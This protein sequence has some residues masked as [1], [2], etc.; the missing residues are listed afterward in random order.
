MISGPG[1]A[2]AAQPG[3][4]IVTDVISLAEQLAAIAE[5]WRPRVVGRLNG[6]EVKL[7][8]FR[9]EFVWHH[10]ESEDELFLGVEGRFRVE[11]RDRVVEIGPG[12]FV[13]VPHGVE[14]R[15]VADEE[16]SVLLFEPAG[17][18]NTGNVEHATLTAPGS[19]AGTHPFGFL[20]DTY[21]TERFKTLAVWSQF[22]DAD[23]GFRPDPRARTPLEQMV[24]QCLSEDTWMR[25]M[26]GI[27]TSLPALPPRETRLDFLRHYAQVSAERLAL[28]K[29]KPPAWYEE[30]TSFFG[31]PRPRSWV[32]VRRMT[33]SSHHRGQL[34]SYLRMLHRDL[35][36]TYGPTADTG[37]LFQDNAPVVYR[38]GSIG[39]LLE[40]EEAGGRWPELPGV[41]G[42]KVTERG[43]R[44][45]SS[46]TTRP[47]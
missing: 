21:D 10:H 27:E 16:A 23:M 14:H 38:Y 6:Q 37:G 5:H 9:G 41:T 30:M 36:S 42:R 44:F 17:V 8:K 15:T 18:R 34:T 20:P 32:V 1:A 45:P 35:Y 26:L 22:G 29:S 39:E 28:L 12:E 25:T 47:A 7:A 46:G 31:E 24:H 33:H 40:G 13:V 43:E 4:G 11:F 19:G 3:E 2:G